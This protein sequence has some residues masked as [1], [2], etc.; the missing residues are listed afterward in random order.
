MD[1]PRVC[2][3]DRI[4]AE[5][6]RHARVA[7]ADRRQAIRRFCHRHRHPELA[8]PLAA[9]TGQE[10][11]LG[12]EVNA[13]ARKSPGAITLSILVQVVVVGPALLIALLL[14]APR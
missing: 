6:Q 3:P 8:V 14:Y 4:N 11:W 7:S 13:I 2:L 1:R 9:D 10:E 5:G 12:V